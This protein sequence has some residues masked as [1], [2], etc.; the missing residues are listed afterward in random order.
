[1]HVHVH[2]YVSSLNNTRMHTCTY[3]HVYTCIHVFVDKLKIW[4]VYMNVHVLTC[5]QMGC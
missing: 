1:M 2:N 5:I 3:V 4:N